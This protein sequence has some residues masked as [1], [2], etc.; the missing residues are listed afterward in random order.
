MAD[1]EPALRERARHAS[2]VNF[3]IMVATT[4]L[5]RQRPDEPA[6]PCC[7]SGEGRC[8]APCWRRSS[9]SYGPSSGV[10]GWVREPVTVPTIASL[11]S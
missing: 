6:P 5:T 4:T 9:A 11:V 8:A 7:R 3:Q 1:R 2:G 10:R